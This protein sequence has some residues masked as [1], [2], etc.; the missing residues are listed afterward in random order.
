MK[1]LQSHYEQLLGLQSPWAVTSVDLQLEANRVQITIEYAK[2]SC[3]YCPVCGQ[4][5]EVYDRRENRQW[6][7]LDTMQFETRM[8]C[9]LARCRCPEHGVKT[10]A[11]PW[12]QKGSGFTLMMEAFAVQVLLA[13]S[14]VQAA[15]KLLGMNWHQ[16]DAI[17]QRAVE[18]GLSRRPSESIE[19]VGMDEKNFGRGHSYVSVLTDLK[20]GRVLEVRQ[21]RDEGAARQLL[22][23]LEPQQRQKV[24]AVAMDMWRPYINAC[25]SELP[26]AD[27][28]HDKFHISQH[29]NAAVDK[30]R[31]AE[32]RQ[33]MKQKDDRLKGS[34]YLWLK[35]FENMSE[36]GQLRFREL[37]KMGL[38]VGRAWS[39]KQTFDYFWHY[40]YERSARKFFQQWYGWARRSQL[41]PIK[42][43]ARMI[44][45]HWERIITYLKHRITNAA[46]EGLNAKIQIIK[47]NARGFRNFQNYRTAILFHCGKLEMLPQ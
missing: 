6:R 31:K 15:R 23:A 11:V 36:Q 18:R 34:K 29:L 44:K 39:I 25:Q 10:V 38:K 43:V 1:T 35:G 14:S 8:S 27:I 32:H 13:S 26:G 12:A 24:Q 47:A 37:Q 16:V 4:P 33:L 17:R 45:R 40:R 46:S 41:E 30:V 3:V 21:G 9:R 7:H 28:V 22:G 42:E 20:A 19:Y 5:C 2:G